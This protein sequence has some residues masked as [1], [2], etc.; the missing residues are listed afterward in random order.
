MQINVKLNFL[1]LVGKGLHR[2]Q[3]LSVSLYLNE[4]ENFWTTIFYDMCNLYLLISRDYKCDQG[5]HQAKT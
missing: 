4:L 2:K 1:R 3:I 5:T